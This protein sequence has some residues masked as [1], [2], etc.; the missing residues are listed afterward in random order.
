MKTKLPQCKKVNGPVRERV[1]EVACE[2]FAEAGFHGTHIRQICERAGTNVAG[3]CYHFQSK[4][5]LYQAVILEA[6]RRLSDIDESFIVSRNLSAEQRLQTLTGSL[7]QRLGA[8]RAWIAKLLAR[9]WVDRACEAN[10]YVASGLE[11]DFALLQAV[12]KDLVG[13]ADNSEDIGIHAFSVIGECVFFALQGENRQHALNQFALCLPNRAD[14][15]RAIT[16]RSLGAL[17]LKPVE[18]EVLNP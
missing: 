9:E 11:R 15:A 7:L 3:V 14:L 4:E 5:G 17:R 12:M 1:L 2:M 13:A 18:P 10:T 8:K 16:Q 6:G